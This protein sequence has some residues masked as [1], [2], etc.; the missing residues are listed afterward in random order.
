MAT[1]KTGGGLVTSARQLDPPSP[2]RN[3]EVT[4]PGIKKGGEPA[5][6]LC[7]QVSSLEWDEWQ[8]SRHLEHSDLRFL[9]VVVRDDNNNRIWPTAEKC[10]DQLGAYSRMALVPLLEAA[11]EL[12]YSNIEDAEKNSEET[13]AD[14]SPSS[15]A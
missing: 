12:N 3:K 2:M 13:K 1:T 14:S 8:E 15:S 6:W 7:W 4:T 9:A 11:N 5:K 10:I